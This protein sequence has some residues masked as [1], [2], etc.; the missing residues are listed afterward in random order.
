MKQPEK[1]KALW[2]LKRF[3]REMQWRLNLEKA[4]CFY[5]HV[6]LTIQWK[7]KA[8][9]AVKKTQMTHVLGDWKHVWDAMAVELK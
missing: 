9:I 8:A 2:V 3:I 4:M 1:M 5:R 6:V 7:L